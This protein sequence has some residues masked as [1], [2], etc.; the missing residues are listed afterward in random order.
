MVKYFKGFCDKQR[1]DKS[2]HVRDVIDMSTEEKDSAVVATLRDD[3]MLTLACA[4]GEFSDERKNSV[5]QAYEYII[6]DNIEKYNLA[7][8]I[9][10]E[11]PRITAEEQML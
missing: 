5:Y 7:V 6:R 4:Y 8:D 3:G 10:N 9:Q 2:G 11:Q 1:K